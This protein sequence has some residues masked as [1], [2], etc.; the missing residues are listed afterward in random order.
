MVDIC[1]IETIISCVMEIGTIYLAKGPPSVRQPTSVLVGLNN[2]HFR[3]PVEW[4]TY[5]YIRC[6]NKGGREITLRF[7]VCHFSLSGLCDS[8]WCYR[9]QIR[10]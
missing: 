1:E 7:H 3:R 10:L 5:L 9:D 6:W 2:R 8:Q 4:S